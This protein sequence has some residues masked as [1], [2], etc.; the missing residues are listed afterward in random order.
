[1]TDTA[2]GPATARRVLG[3]PMQDN[4]ADAATIR[5]YLITLL[6]TL[7]RKGEGFSGKRPLGNGGWEYELYQPLV[8]A[9]LITGRF[10]EELGLEDCDADAADALIGAAIRELG[11]A[12]HAGSI[13]LAPGDWAATTDSFGSRVQGRV[14]FVTEDEDGSEVTIAVWQGDLVPPM[15]VRGPADQFTKVEGAD[16]A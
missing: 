3:L 2:I 15:T 5:D 12:P 11:A 8:K 13:K 9:G 1:V 10:D 16:H 4:D 6:A 7:W 14:I